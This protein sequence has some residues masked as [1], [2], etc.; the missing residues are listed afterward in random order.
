M[1]IN[2]QQAVSVL[3]VFCERTPADDKVRLFFNLYDADGDGRVS[4]DNLRSTL[5]LVLP[6]LDHDLI[7]HAVDQTLWE[8][9]GNKGVEEGLALEQFAMVVADLVGERGTAFFW[10]LQVHKSGTTAMESAM[11]YRHEME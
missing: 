2:F 11:L 3:G 9:A 6:D 4:R 8:L 10:T 1:G 7:H 5:K